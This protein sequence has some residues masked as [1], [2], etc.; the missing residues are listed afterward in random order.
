MSTRKDYE[1]VAA[2]I[3]SQRDREISEVDNALDAL[4]EDIAAYFEEDSPRF[5]RPRFLKAA[6]AA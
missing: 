1:A 4:A 6:G 3:R 2:S 5:D